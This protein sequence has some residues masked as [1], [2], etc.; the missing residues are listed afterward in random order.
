MA[1]CT[2]FLKSHILKEKYMTEHYKKYERS[3]KSKTLKMWHVWYK[4][5]CEKISI[6]V[7]KHILDKVVSLFSY[8][9][10]SRGVLSKP[11]NVT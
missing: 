4:C 1:Y 6:K 3:M 7:E 5:N 2:L 9:N 10:A 11:I 8:C